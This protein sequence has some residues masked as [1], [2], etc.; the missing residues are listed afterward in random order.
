MSSQDGKNKMNKVE[1]NLAVNN[2]K[3]DL[4][5]MIGRDVDKKIIL[6][7]IEKDLNSKLTTKKATVKI[8]EES[9][10]LL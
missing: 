4:K 3:E 6:N 10:Y 5:T 7:S 9:I 8:K 2:E 1:C